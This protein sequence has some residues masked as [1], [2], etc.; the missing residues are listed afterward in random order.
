GF[1]KGYLSFDQ[2]Y[3]AFLISR[4][5]FI[6]AQAKQIESLSNK[7]KREL[8]WLRAGVKARTTKSSARQQEAHELLDKL[9]SS[10]SRQRQSTAKISIQID[11]T[12]RKTKKLIELKA[13]NKA[14]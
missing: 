4:E 2:P 1:E 11:A 3:D 14:Y 13:V 12:D 6:E 10:L 5:Q 7:A 8:D 9:D